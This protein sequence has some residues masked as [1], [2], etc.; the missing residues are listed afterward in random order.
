[1]LAL[2]SHAGGVTAVAFSPEGK[3][4]VSTGFDRAVRFWD[5]AAGREAAALE[6]HVA[7]INTLAFSPDGRTLATGSDDGTV[8]LWPWRLLLEAR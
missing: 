5:L 4:V 7:A 6:W 8:R 1:V 2:Q 3:Y